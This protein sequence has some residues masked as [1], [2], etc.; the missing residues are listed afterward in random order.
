[1][2]PAAGPAEELALDDRPLAIAVSV[3]GRH[4]IVTLPW[5]LW[6]VDARLLSTQRTIA[7]NAA[8]PSVVEGWEGALWIG[9]Q[10]LYKGNLSSTAVT[11]VG[12]KL[13]GVVDHVCL[14][15]DDLLCGVGAQGEILW[16]IDRQSP[17]H[18]RKSTG[19]AATAVVASADGRAVFADGSSHCWIIDPAH[20]AGY[21]KLQLAATSPVPV[22]GEAIVCLGRTDG[23]RGGRVI[24]AAR[25]GAVAWTSADLRLAGE[26]VPAG[27]RDLTPLA[28]AGDERWIYVLRGRGLLQRFLVSQP[29]EV[30]RAQKQSG[31]K[32]K[33]MPV[34]GQRQEEPPQPLPEAQEVR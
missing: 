24:L 29:P 28:V 15:R 25:D 16:D 27:K 34:P 10:H 22:P 5:E 6:I 9:G 21:G 20:P 17:T 11:K 32:R 19:P 13:G 30:L 14:V 18:R 3:D 2:A 1:M 26:R 7:L 31:K 23:T 12:S 33:G 4:L 8:R